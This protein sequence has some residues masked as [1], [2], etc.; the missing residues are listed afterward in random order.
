LTQRV[1]TGRPTPKAAA[2]IAT[3]LGLKVSAVSL[4]QFVTSRAVLSKRAGSEASVASWAA[5]CRS[6]A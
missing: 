2:R 1:T 3:G 4:R 5:R 6:G